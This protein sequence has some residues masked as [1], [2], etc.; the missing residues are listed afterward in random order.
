MI[1]IERSMQAWKILLD[2]L[3]DEQDSILSLLVIL[4]KSRI[5]LTALVPNYLQFARPGFDQ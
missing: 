3:E 5:L 4:E 1:S 2:A